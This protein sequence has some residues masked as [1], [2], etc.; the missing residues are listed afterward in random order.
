MTSGVCGIQALIW[1]LVVI[2]DQALET[3]VCSRS[4][5]ARFYMSNQTGSHA[6]YCG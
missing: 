2:A 6:R 3:P 4:I 5:A 1:Q